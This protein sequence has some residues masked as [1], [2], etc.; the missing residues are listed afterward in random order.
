MDRA[1]EEVRRPR[2]REELD[3]YLMAA[4][5]VYGDKPES[6]EV[7]QAFANGWHAAL[8]WVTAEQVKAALE[9]LEFRLE[10]PR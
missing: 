7:R 8:A 10:L 3:A 2:G 9:G 4:S 5:L 1:T 6:E